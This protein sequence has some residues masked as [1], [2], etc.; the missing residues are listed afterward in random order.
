[1]PVVDETR[2]RRRLPAW[3]LWLA[4]VLLPL[5]VLGT[6]LVLP[7]FVSWGA[8]TLHAGVWYPLSGSRGWAPR[9]GVSYSVLLGG[10]RVFAIRYGRW[11]YSVDW[12]PD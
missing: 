11:V 7:V 1:M 9:P 12:V 4:A 6:T 2:V 8:G 10:S 5:L 3:V